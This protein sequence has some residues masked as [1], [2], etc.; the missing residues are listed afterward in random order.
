M[1]RLMRVTRKRR[2]IFRS[3]ARGDTPKARFA[4]LLRWLISIPPIAGRSVPVRLALFGGSTYLFLWIPDIDQL[5]LPILHHRS[6]ITHSLLPGF[7]LLLLGRSLGAAPAAG[8]LIG[9]SVHLACDMLSPM[10]G[11][12]AIWTPAPYKISLG[13][14]S[15]IWLAGNAVLGFAIASIIARA[16]FGELFAYP[17]VVILSVVTGLIYGVHNEGSLSSVVIVL[18]LLAA[19]LAPEAWVRHRLFRKAEKEKAAGT[20]QK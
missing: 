8:A 3:R 14:F 6:I 5:F 19:S 12:G 13:V 7:L 18:V 17:L 2:D 20:I 1:V 10:V 16:A 4:E 11:F 15:Y 9:L